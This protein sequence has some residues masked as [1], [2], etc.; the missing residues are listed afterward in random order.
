[1]T[2]AYEHR[3]HLLTLKLNDFLALYRPPDHLNTDQLKLTKLRHIADQV[4]EVIPSGIGEDQFKGIVIRTFKDVEKTCKRGTWPEVGH[5][6][7]CT[8]RENKRAINQQIGDAR[9]T[10]DWSLDS[11]RIWEERLARGER[12]SEFWL[13][14]R[15]E[16]NERSNDHEV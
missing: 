10:Q 3:M 16:A 5:F 14:R 7:D 4:N 15:R 9:T 8:E 6:V 13:K 11:D 1:M 12:V 2:L